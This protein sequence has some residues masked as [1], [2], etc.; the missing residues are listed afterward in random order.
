MG[1]DL[2]ADDESMDYQL[3]SGHTTSPLL[4]R[5]AATM[6]LSSSAWQCRVPMFKAVYTTNRMGLLALALQ[7]CQDCL[8]KTR[9]AVS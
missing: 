6:L 7:K 4:V 1:G 2:V 8:G 3:Q 5:F 9:C